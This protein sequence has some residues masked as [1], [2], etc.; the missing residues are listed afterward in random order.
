MWSHIIN[1]HDVG[2]FNFNYNYNGCSSAGG[3]RFNSG[4]IG[5]HHS[6]K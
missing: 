2:Y 5:E 4:T 1:L 3:I 6:G